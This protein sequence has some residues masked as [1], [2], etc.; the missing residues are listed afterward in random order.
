MRD[1]ESNSDNPFS[2]R[3]SLFQ[4]SSLVPSYRRINPYYKC[5]IHSPIITLEF[6]I[7][8]HCGKFAPDRCSCIR[9][10]LDCQDLF[11]QISPRHGARRNVL[12]NINVEKPKIIKCGHQFRIALNSVQA[13]EVCR[14][15]TRDHLITLYLN[16]PLNMES[17]FSS[18]P[19][20]YKST[21]LRESL[22]GMP[23]KAKP[24]YIGTFK[25][26]LSR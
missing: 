23:S 10:I 6:S 21:Y 26:D 1:S 14:K 19:R 11:H 22:F 20:L 5:F 8:S 4:L 3:N 13:L 18:R 2:Q 9:K 7:F 16:V 24:L 17:R 25:A 12:V 15:I